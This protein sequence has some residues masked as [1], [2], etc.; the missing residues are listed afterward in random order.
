MFLC[1]C[2]CLFVCSE[3]IEELVKATDLKFG[4]GDREYC[5]YKQVEYLK[6]IFTSSITKGVEAF[7]QLNSRVVPVWISS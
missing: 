1:L 3:L 2:V 4:G 7:S 5:M 6:K